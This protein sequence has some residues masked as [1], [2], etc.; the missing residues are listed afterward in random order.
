VCAQGCTV[1]VWISRA[2]VFDYCS[3]RR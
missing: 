2:L 3:R 1:N